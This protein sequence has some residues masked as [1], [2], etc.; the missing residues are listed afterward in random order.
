MNRFEEDDEAFSRLRRR[1][2]SPS[3]YRIGIGGGGGRRWE[4]DGPTD[5]DG[6]GEGVGGF[7]QMNGPLDRLDFQPMGPHHGGSLRPMGFAFDGG[8][9]EGKRSIVGAGGG[10][11][12]GF[13]LNGPVKFPP[14]KSPDG[15]R[16]IG[17]VMESDYSVRPVQQPL[18]GQKR[19]HHSLSEHESFTGTGKRRFTLLSLSLYWNLLFLWD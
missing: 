19:G 16:F 4:G 6:P 15:G 17:K 10:G 18:S 7:R 12:G 1:G 9:G 8:V 2:N 11:G 5:F 3:S 13:R 14:S